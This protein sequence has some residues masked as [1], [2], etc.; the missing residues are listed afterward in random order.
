VP[1][2]AVR[3]AVAGGTTDA[4]PA[5]AGRHGSAPVSQP[6]RL[7]PSIAVA[8]SGEWLIAFHANTGALW[9]RGSWGGGGPVPGAPLIARGTSPSAVFSPGGGWRIAFQAR[10]GL[11]HTAT[12]GGD[13]ENLGLGLAPGTSPSIAV[14][15]TGA[16]LIAF[17]AN[18]GVLWT[19]NSFGGGGPVPGNPTLAP[20]TSPSVIALK[21]GGFQIAYQASNGM[22]HTAAPSGEVTSLGLG[23]ARGTSPSIAVLPTDAWLIAFQANTGVLWTRTSSD[24]GGPL[25]AIVKARTSPSVSPGGENFHVSFQGADGTLSWAFSSGQAVSVGLPMSP[26]SSPAT[27]FRPGGGWINAV[28]ADTGL[29]WTMDSAGFSENL[30]LGMPL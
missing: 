25:P 27:A 17:Q 18:T 28:E 9:T 3:A 2:T 10:S 12:P 14:L 26:G 8:G 15:P 13:V 19:R 29:L 21:T 1:A 5:G 23:M 16:W 6:D 24:G 20:G 11:L 7:G 30:G 4:A 22:L